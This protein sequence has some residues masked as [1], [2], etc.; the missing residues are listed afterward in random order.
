LW[1]ISDERKEQAENERSSIM[2]NGW[3]EDHLGILDNHYITLMQVE[4]DCFQDT[5]QVLKDYY[6]GMEGRIPE[7]INTEYLCLPLLEVCLYLSLPL[8]K[9]CSNICVSLLE[10]SFFICLYFVNVM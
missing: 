7:E 1:S 4:V 9:V 6:T 5:V 3:L 8:L 10:M 2:G